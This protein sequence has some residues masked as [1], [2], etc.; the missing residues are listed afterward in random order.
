MS[1]IEILRQ[2]MHRLQADSQQEVR[3]CHHFHSITSSG[4]SGLIAVLLGVFGLTI[5]ETAAIFTQVC[6]DVFSDNEATSEARTQSLKSSLTR[7]FST[8]GITPQA[9][10]RDNF[11]S[12]DSCKVSIG[13]AAAA[14]MGSWRSFKNY[15]TRNQASYDITIIDAIVSAW[16]A[17]GVI[18]NISVGSALMQEELTGTMMAF[19]NPTIEALKEA[20]DAFSPDHRV[21]CVI[22]IGSGKKGI[23]SEFSIEDFASQQTEAVSEEAEKRFGGLN[24]YF[25]FSLER[26]LEKTVSPTP[27]GFGVIHSHVQAYL[28][29]HTNDELLDRSIEASKV[30]SQR[31]IRDLVGEIESSRS[32]TAHNI[33]P[34]SPF[35]VIRETPML[36]MTEALLMPGEGG[37]KIVVLSGMGGSG[38]TQLAIK[39]ARDNFKK[40]QH[41]FFIDASS[42]ESI[43]SDLVTHISAVDPQF[44]GQS[45]DDALEN[46]AHPN[47]Y[48]TTQWLLI[49]DNA[50]SANV[51]MLKA[52]PSC[53]HGYVLITTRRALVEGVAPQS[54]IKLDV[55]SSEEAVEA[56]LSSALDPDEPLSD[57]GREVALEIVTQLG[58]LPVAVIQAGC[59]INK[60]KCLYDYLNRFRANRQRILNQY[61]RQ[62]DHLDN[63]D[64]LYAVFDTTLDAI[65]PQS[66]QLLTILSFLHFTNFPRQVF[67]LAASGGF[68]YQRYDLMERQVDFQQAIAMLRDTLCPQGPWDEDVID[69]ILEEL[70]LYSLVSL[71]SSP[72]AVMLRF[73]PLLHGWAQDRLLPEQRPQYRLAAVRL[74]TCGSHDDARQYR[75]HLRPHLEALLPSFEEIHVNDQ[76]S[77]A[78]LIRIEPTRKQWGHDLW[79]TIHRKV[80]AAHGET[81]V[82]TSRALIQ[83][84]HTHG[85]RGDTAKEEEL[86]RKALRIRRSLCG[87]KHLETTHAAI[88][89]AWHLYSAGPTPRRVRESKA[90]ARDVLEIREAQLGPD[91]EKVAEVLVTLGIAY[92]LQG[93]VSQAQGYF[94]RAVQV[95]TKALGPN[96]LKTLECK[97]R[98]ATCY[99]HLKDPRAEEL[100]REV[101]RGREINFGAQHINS[102]YAM[103][104]LASWHYF[105][106]RYDLAEAEWRKILEDVRKIQGDSHMDTLHAVGCLAL[107]LYQLHRYLE[108]EALFKE[109]VRGRIATMGPQH[110]A[111]LR[112]KSHLSQCMKASGSNPNRVSRIL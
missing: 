111:T 53:D 87:P 86:L 45:I 32:S 93:K 71:V 64:G 83:L 18:D 47:A 10:M 95:T 67:T 90:L 48:V 70:Q 100:H 105:S 66:L 25:R 40:F 17:P 59:Y 60:Q 99:A 68:S 28:S 27:E 112:A 91:D 63:R 50:D 41:V 49:M 79:I 89:L 106:R 57:Q 30:T 6:V 76:G 101:I 15:E 65:S 88:H 44:K 9:R 82:Q 97:G 52:I 29:R 39:F 92:F 108:A 37:Q 107:T 55:M 43:R 33:P 72:S 20:R 8:N 7:V 26:G 31:K 16:A 24:L 14:N 84:A 96:N 102:I 12:R 85:F 34:L 77:L 94:E 54:H 38:K 42:I 23:V 110:P 1:Q 80:L 36:R 5:D 61:T 78:E 75:E 11:G 4:A 2:Y 73:H 51:N 104:S 35:F 81:S 3:P 69:G 98:L 13:Y 103:A 46:L 58:H 109:E 19:N 74:L 21:S 56:L 62:R 22:S